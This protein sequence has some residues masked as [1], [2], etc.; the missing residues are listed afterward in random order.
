MLQGNISSRG[1]NYCLAL[2]FA[3]YLVIVLHTKQ[4]MSRFERLQSLLATLAMPIYGK[5]KKKIRI[6]TTCV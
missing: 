5:K 2:S 3:K 6:L 1:G 4:N